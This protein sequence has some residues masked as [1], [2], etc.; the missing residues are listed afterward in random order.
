MKEKMIKYFSAN[1]TRKYLD[2]LDEM[3]NNYNN[4]RHSSIKMT[5]FE[6]SLK[7]N[8]TTVYRN[9]YPK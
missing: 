6:A 4:T 3:V 2:V 8:E 5:H 7:K 9:F 1:S